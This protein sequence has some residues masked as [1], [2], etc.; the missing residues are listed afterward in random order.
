M[1]MSLIVV[2]NVI[3]EISLIKIV[4]NYLLEIKINFDFHFHNCDNSY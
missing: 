2:A 4:S 1:T 3:I